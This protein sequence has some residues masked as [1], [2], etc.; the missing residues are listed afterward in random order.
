MA[1]IEFI[2]KHDSLCRSSKTRTIA[3]P[4]QP[5]EPVM[6]EPPSGVPNGITGLNRNGGKGGSGLRPPSAHSAGLAREPESELRLRYQQNRTGSS[7]KSPP[8]PTTLSA[9]SSCYLDPDFN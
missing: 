6:M 2:I 5:V 9:V 4:Q 8:C 3:Q 1:Y 7:G